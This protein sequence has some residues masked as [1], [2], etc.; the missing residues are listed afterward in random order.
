MNG[1]WFLALNPG[2]NVFA[3]L[4]AFQSGTNLILTW[5]TNAIGFTLQTAASLQSPAGWVDI[6]ASPSVVGAQFNVT[7]A[8]MGAS[9]FYRLAR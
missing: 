1:P 4:A 6:T 9:Q 7:N 8:M 2:L 3:N 5:P